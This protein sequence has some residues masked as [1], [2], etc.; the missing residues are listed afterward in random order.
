MANIDCVNTTVRNMSGKAAVFGFLPPHGKKLEAGEE[1][2]FFGSIESLLSKVTSGRKR[3]GF[4]AAVQSGDLVV[5][6]G[7]TP[8]LYDATLDVSKTIK[9]DNNSFSTT[10][11][12]GVGFSSSI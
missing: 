11:P 3:A 12:F 2:T 1:Y 4:T 7:P 10:D 8:I 5:V 6:S 9:L